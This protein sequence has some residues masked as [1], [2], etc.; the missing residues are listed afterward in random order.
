MDA[1]C[2]AAEVPGQ[3]KFVVN[4]G[5]V[6][7]RHDYLGLSAHYYLTLDDPGLEEMETLCTL[8]EGDILS[9]HFF[10]CDKRPR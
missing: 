5:S 3:L 9:T 1:Y 6:I 8:P 2:R 7:G 4:V 10:V